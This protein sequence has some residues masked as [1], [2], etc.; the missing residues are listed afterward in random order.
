MIAFGEYRKLI[1]YGGTDATGPRQDVWELDLSGAGPFTW[2]Q[3]T[4]DAAPALAPGARA[5]GVLIGS[6]YFASNQAVFLFGG[7]TTTGPTSDVWV[8]SRQSAG[9]LLI[10]AP[11]GLTA[12]D[13]ATNMSM[14]IRS[15]TS[16]FFGS[17]LY[18][19]N[20]ARSR[21]DFVS[22][23]LFGS[24]FATLP[25]PLGYLQPDGNFYFLFASRNRSTPT[26]NNT[27]NFVS[28]DGLEA[29]LDFE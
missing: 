18:I 23:Q 27:A 8:L 10:K 9:R 25:R 1:L 20:G 21:W 26:N 24:A 2:R 4:L 5:N 13:L 6:S 17:P 3:L 28:L 11:A 7:T 14:S 22:F 12:P 16:S 19:W 29:T 15:T